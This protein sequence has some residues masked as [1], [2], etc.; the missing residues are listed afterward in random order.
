MQTLWLTAWTSRV[1]PALSWTLIH[2]LWQGL[3]LA[4]VS[5]LLLIMTRKASAAVRYTWVFVQFLLFLLTVAGTFVYEY[6]HDVT[7]D[8]L[9]PLLHVP[10]GYDTGGQLI[11]T[12]SNYFTANAP[13]IVMIWLIIFIARLVRVIAAQVYARRIRNYKVYTPAGY[14]QQRVNALAKTL[15]LE[16]AVVLLESGYV[17][18]PVI[19]GSFRPVILIPLGLLT[20]LPAAQ[21]EAVLLH[22][23]AHIR[24]GDYFVNYL[25]HIAEAIFFFNPGLLWVSALLREERENCCDDIAIGQTGNKED[26]VQ[27]LISFKEHALYGSA[28][29]TAFPGKK[30]QLLQRVV[31]IVSN[32]NKTLSITESIFFAASILVLSV[33]LV[34]AVAQ[35]RGTRQTDTITLIAPVTTDT[36]IAPPGTKP[37]RLASL[38]RTEQFK[39]EQEQYR[40]QQR[41]YEEEAKKQEVQRSIYEQQAGKY[42][43]QQRIYEAQAREYEARA[44]VI[45]YPRP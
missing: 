4:I 35:T 37:V 30:N 6:N 34:A 22:E 8:T 26:F 11:H 43:A 12:F 15:K 7:A 10:V 19:A 20:G 29:A 32:R 31:R 33:M 28:Y 27:A 42:A 21:V 17:K 13:L 1:I 14:W 2:S 3:L 18:V 24:R 44:Q 41:I 9:L 39:K 5:G 40:Q 25:Q 16:R 23:L 38:S 45:N 36:L